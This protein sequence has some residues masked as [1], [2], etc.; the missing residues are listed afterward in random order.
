[1]RRLCLL[2]FSLVSLLLVAYIG[3]DFS[4]SQHTNASPL[5]AE[6]RTG[7][8]T[9]ASYSQFSPSS[10]DISNTQHGEHSKAFAP[11][12]TVHSTRP[13]FHPQTLSTPSTPLYEDVPTLETFRLS[14]WNGDAG[15]ITGIWIDGHMAFEVVPGVGN[16][17]PTEPNTAST[18]EWAAAHGVTALLI[19]NHL[20]GTR[21]YDLDLGAMIALISGDGGIAW[22]SA[23][24]SVWYE[25]E[26]YSGEGFAGPFR[27][28]TC[29]QCEFDLSVRDLRWRHYAGPHHLAIQTCVQMD[30]RIGLVI[31][32][33]QPIE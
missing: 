19:H 13:H 30:D 16:Y 32:E 21:I 15:Q 22:Y 33:A 9:S 17:V 26:S 4:R 11:T 29:T 25:A 7:K 23:S 6:Y 10:N 2:L 8:H 20:G 12:P 28:W 27:S 1:M 14:V 31:F 5:T 18:Y 24:G 3:L